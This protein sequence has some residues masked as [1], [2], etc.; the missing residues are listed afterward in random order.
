MIFCWSCLINLIRNI[1]E[2]IY[3]TSFI[4]L[5]LLQWIKMVSGDSDISLFLFSITHHF[6]YRHSTCH[7]QNRHYTQISRSSADLAFGKS[8]AL[9]CRIIYMYI[10]RYSITLILQNSSWWQVSGS[11]VVWNDQ[12]FEVLKLKKCSSQWDANNPFARRA[13]CVRKLWF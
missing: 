3:L 7:K 4:I 8:F 10:H 11:S 9:H 1:S 5:D 2:L 12:I 6:S 13:Y